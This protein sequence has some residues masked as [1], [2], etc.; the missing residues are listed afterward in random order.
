MIW[1]VV[2]WMLVIR[3]V[4]CC[5]WEW[6]RMTRENVI[7]VWSGKLSRA[8]S[9]PLCE[10][11]RLSRADSLVGGHLIV[12]WYEKWNEKKWEEMW[13]NVRL[14]HP[15]LIWNDLILVDDLVENCWLRIVLVEACLG[16]TLNVL[17]EEIDVWLVENYLGWSWLYFIV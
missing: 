2:N 12:K 5:D 17:N 13:G 15:F 11:A 9:Y 3:N 7:S 1:W 10:M 16:W 14:S 4:K 6:E 8:D